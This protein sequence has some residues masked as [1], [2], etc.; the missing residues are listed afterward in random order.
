MQADLIFAGRSYHI[1]GNLI[2]HLL[3][4]KV[5][6]LCILGNFACFICHLLMF[7]NKTY[8]KNSLR[9]TIRV[10]DSFDS[11]RVNIPVDWGLVEEYSQFF[12]LHRFRPSIYCYKKKLGISGIP[13]KIFPLCTLTLK[14]PL[15]LVD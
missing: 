5:L 2:M 1:V 8:S 9:N 14:M 3:I 12:L 11:N 13:Q 7:S 6:T 15:K 4:Y 10:P